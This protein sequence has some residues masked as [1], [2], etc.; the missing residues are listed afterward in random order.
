MIFKFLWI[1]ISFL[2][3]SLPLAVWIGRL[4]G[5]DIRQYGDGNPGA[6][7]VLRAAGWPWYILAL[8]ADISKAAMPVGLAYQIFGW[9]DWWIV[10]IALAPPLGHAFSPFLDWQGGKA[11]ATLLGTWIGLTYWIVPSAGI[12][13][14]IIF[15]G[16]LKGDAWAVL[17]SMALLHLFIFFI[18]PNPIFMTIIFLQTLLV[19]WTHWHGLRHRPQLRFLATKS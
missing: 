1:I 7:N 16:L 17:I 10:P 11:L 3:G 19:I 12:I 6:T 5:K 4:A 13:S 8:I 14:L 15:V 2:A 18:L 9:Q